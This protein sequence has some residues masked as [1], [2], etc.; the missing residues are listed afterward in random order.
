[1]PL[2]LIPPDHNKGILED[3]FFRKHVACPRCSSSLSIESDCLVCKSGC[4]Y[5]IING[6]PVMLEENKGIF[7]IREIVNSKGQYVLPEIYNYKTIRKS[8]KK[9]M[10]EIAI[11]LGAKKNISDFIKLLESKKRE[12]KVLIIGGRILGKGISQMVKHPNISIV[13]G[14]VYWGPRTNIIF[15]AHKIPFSDSTFDG[16]IIQSVLEHVLD[17]KRCVE[18]I[19]RVLVSDGIVYAESSFMEQVHGGAFDFW[20]FTHLGHRTLFR[21]FVEIESGA[22][23]GP[24]SVLVWSYQYF[25]LS[26]TEN[27]MMRN[28]IKAFVRATSFWVKYLDHYLINKPGALD[29][30]SSYYFIGRKNTLALSDEELIKEYRGAQ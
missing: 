19:H 5:P 24:A 25:L 4:S 21:A 3:S 17:P 2:K 20:R 7:S 30:A 23:N 26:F 22:V 12:P 18:E 9:L 14:D 15:D 27:K 16:V 1:L 11:N 13:E 28:L 29:D 8:A 10:P 6:I